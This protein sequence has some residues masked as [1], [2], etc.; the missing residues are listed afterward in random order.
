[1]LQRRG[2]L[3]VI[4]LTLTLSGCFRQASDDFEP[5]DSGDQGAQEVIP[6]PDI[7]P[8]ATDDGGVTL[9]TSTPILPATETPIEP[10]ST[11][12]TA[13]VEP[14]STEDDSFIPPPTNTENNSFIPP[15]T[16]TVEPTEDTSAQQVPATNTE[17]PTQTESVVNP[18][19]QTITESPTFIT[20]NAPNPGLPD[21]AT[22]SPTHTS[23][24]GVNPNLDATPTG[25]V[26]PT[27]DCVYTVQAGDNLYRIAVNNNTTLDELRLANP[28]IVGDLIQPGDQLILPAEGCVEGGVDAG[29]DIDPDDDGTTAELPEGMQAIHVVQ[30]GETL[31]IIARRY[32]VTISDVAQANEIT[33]INRISVNQ[34]LL[35]PFPAEDDE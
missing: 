16:N 17:I 5:V 24:P 14:T 19:E 13:D 34:E 9:M 2:F 10:T 1:M 3:L 33:N 12:D 30:P 22:P 4:A 32:G 20:P 28:E 7:Q 18:P 8:T 21:T 31:N 15:P 35:I 23:L 29:I 11:E 25:I 6:S 27:D 26:I